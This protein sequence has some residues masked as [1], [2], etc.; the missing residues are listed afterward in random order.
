MRRHKTASRRD[1]LP[2]ARLRIAQFLCARVT[3]VDFFRYLPLPICGA[4][5]L[6]W[7]AGQIAIPPGV[8]LLPGGRV[9][10]VAGKRAT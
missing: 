3:S 10:A 8:V 5:A 7:L 1:A 6:P 4:G 2:W 9:A